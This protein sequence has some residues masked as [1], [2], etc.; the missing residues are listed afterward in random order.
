MLEDFK[1]HIENHFPFLKQNAFLIAIS[2]GVDSVVL[3][4]LFHELHYDF[5][6]AHC[7]FNLRNEE[8]DEDEAFVRR[9]GE[10]LSLKTFCQTFST[11]E[12]ATIHKKSI[13]IA[14]RELRYTWFNSLLKTTEFSYVLTAHHADD[15]LETFL[16]NLTR[17]SGLEGLIGIPQQNDKIVR[18]LLAFSR[19]QIET[20]AVK[21]KIQWRNDASNAEQK[22]LRNKIRHGLVPILK[23]IAPNIL[24]SYKKVSQ[25]LIESK[26]IIDDTIKKIEGKVV[27]KE[28]DLIKIDISEMLKLSNP[29]AYLFQL[30]KSFNF[31]EWNN[32]NDLLKSQSGKRVVS[33]THEILKDREFLLVYKK[34]INEKVNSNFQVDLGTQKVDD[35]TFL[36]VE[37]SSKNAVQNK[38]SI[39]VNKN[40]VTFPMIIRKWE[41]G[42]FFYPTGMKGKKKVSKFFKDEKLSKFQ[43]ERTWLLCTKE[44][45]IIWVVG[46]RQDRRFSASISTN[47][48]LKISI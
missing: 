39:I 28:G 37:K 48:V 47:D 2:G 26:M 6:I 22:Y 24:D 21:N 13:Q 40:L 11:Q 12:Y 32:V 17:G 3:T 43:K 44:N 23:E 30:L 34:T 38:K 42:D 36:T 35:N 20:Y 33:K 14:A 5:G 18:P 1:L 15:N 7:N 46:M 41:V 25:N 4:H 8:S 31:S 19:H 10:E 9:L 45:E 27:K 29:K 16:I